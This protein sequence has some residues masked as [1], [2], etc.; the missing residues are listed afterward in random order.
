MTT[1]ELDQAAVAAFTQQLVGIITGGRLSLMISIG[2][3]TS[4]FDA[5]AG[6]PPS[7][8]EQIA[9][10]AGLNER[11]VR[12]WLGAMA[13]GRVV[14]YDPASRAYR[15]PAEHAAVLTRAAG[16][17]NMAMMAQPVAL[18]GMV[19][20]AI[21]ECFRAGGGVPYDAYPSRFQ[22]LI[23]E[24]SARVHDAAL[25]DRIV[26]LVP[27]LAER[28]QAG[29]DVADIGCGT[30][31]A[32][33]LLA[34]ASPASRFVGYDT[35]ADAIHVARAEAEALALGNARFRVQDAATLEE[36]DAFDVI[37]AFDAIHDLARPREALRA[38]A[39]ALRPGGTFLMVDVA[40]FSN[41]EENLDH[42]PAA[43]F[44]VNS[45][46]Y[47]LPVSLAQGGEG[48]GAMWG[49]Q[50]ARRY[51]ADAGFAHVEVRRLDGD[52]VNNYYICTKG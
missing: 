7:T 39:R 33:N 19:E 15:L 10:A 14:A 25:V 27:G 49:E 40:A 48:L 20:D 51:L 22:Q 29:I 31:H 32:V 42:P 52:M 17:R 50:T 23:A 6:L 35:S 41:L 47:C 44:Y 5:M 26:P 46:M 28:L 38:I 18:F 11:Y 36:R 37:T 13:C 16:I 8:S 45:T 34:R 43:S 30:G 2:H 3:R 4:L 21:I 1:R 12:E 9:E 24:L